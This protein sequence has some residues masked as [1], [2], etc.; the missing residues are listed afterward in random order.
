[1]ENPIIY[2]LLK[3]LRAPLIQL[4]LA[5]AIAVFGLTLIPGK[6]ADG[7]VWYFS[8]FHAFY[9]FSY[10]ATTIGFGEI[11][12]E[13][14]EQ[15]RLW[16]TFC[17]YLTVITWLMAIGKIIGLFQDP[18][19]RAAINKY[20][21]S[22]KIKHINQKFC[23]V[24]GYG[25]TGEILV[26]HLNDKGFSCV[27]IDQDPM[28]IQILDLDTSIHNIPCLHGDASDVSILKMAGIN[29]D[30]CK[31][32][33]AVTNDDNVNVKISVAS[34]LLRREVKVICKTQ[35]KEAMANAKSFDTDFVLNPYRI[36]AENM[37]MTFRMPSI[38]QLIASLLKR[39]GQN[40]AEKIM[41]PKGNW[42]ICGYQRFGQ[43]MGRFLD[44]EGIDFTVVDQDIDESKP[45]SIKGK[46]TE[47]VTLR[48]AGLD[49]AV[50]IIAGTRNDADNLSIIMTARHYRPNI[51]LVARQNQDNNTDIFNSANVDII[52]ESARLMVWQ[53][54]PRLTQP[55]LHNFFRLVRHQDEEWGQELIVKLKEISET[56]PETFILKI[57]RKRSP[58]IIHQLDTGT[59]LRLQDLISNPQDLG[60]IL[61]VVPLMLVRDGKET[62]LPKLS[63]AIKTGDILLFAGTD[64]AEQQIRFA[65]NNAHELYYLINGKEKPVSIVLERLRA[66]LNAKRLKRLRG[67]KGF[68]ITNL[69]RNSAAT[70]NSESKESK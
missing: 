22:K 39:S 52:M 7:N 69:I 11:P 19:F 68:K 44:F 40:Y 66:L 62:L 55:Y 47:I 59:I 60:Q 45:N 70:N 32:V 61:P 23:I 12:Y 38:Q 42:I 50:G 43:E 18:A 9:F 3:R 58:A 56:V 27:V 2:L 30:K 17:I 48:A 6:D 26:N 10:V 51:Y 65:A 16:V 67:L 54:V 29:H 14:S 13:F 8:Y 24:C 57:N 34:K 35:S 28:R 20:Q 46:G 33:I 37:A 25:E 1:M 5:Y 49:E 41:L 36:F 21:F 64:F 4:I 63:T 53:I 31:A 15:Q